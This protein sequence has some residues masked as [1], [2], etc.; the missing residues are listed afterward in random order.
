MSQPEHRAETFP[1][2]SMAVIMLGFMLGM[3]KNRVVNMAI[4][5]GSVVVSGPRIVVGATPDDGPGPVVH[6]T[7][8]PHHS[9]AI[10]TKLEGRDR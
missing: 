4:V 7:M 10:L 8:I 3:Y 5:T 1:A 6:A 2:E 9:I